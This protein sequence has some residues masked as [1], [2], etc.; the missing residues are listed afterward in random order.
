MLTTEQLFCERVAITA[1]EILNHP[2]FVQ[3]PDTVLF[4]AL[5][6]TILDDATK[7]MVLDLR[8]P[9]HWE[10]CHDA[11]MIYVVLMLELFLVLAPDPDV[12]RAQLMEDLKTKPPEVP[13]DPHGYPIDPRHRAI[14]AHFR[15][16]PKYDPRFD[17]VMPQYAD[18]EVGKFID[19]ECKRMRNILAQWRER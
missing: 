8:F 14:E 6:A 1:R 2:L 12:S 18:G 16:L 9:K 15:Y 19:R 4:D 7:R 10:R 13:R 3:H 5:L 11:Y 17:G